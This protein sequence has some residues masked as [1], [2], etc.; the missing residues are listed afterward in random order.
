MPHEATMMG[1]SG[2]PGR[3]GAPTW[4]AAR[5]RHRGQ[6]DARLGEPRG[7]RATVKRGV[8]GHKA[9]SGKNKSNGDE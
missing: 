1:T 7:G 9:D 5:P 2:L 8:G 6:P 3:R 4:G